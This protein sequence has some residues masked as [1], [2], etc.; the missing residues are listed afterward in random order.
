[1]A[2]GDPLIL[3][4]KI[5]GVNLDGEGIAIVMSCAGARYEL[6]HFIFKTTAEGN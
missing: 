5:W 3:T 1:M 6:I 4:T 2:V